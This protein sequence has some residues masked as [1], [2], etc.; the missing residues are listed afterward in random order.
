MA[1]N[2]KSGASRQKHG[3][4][5]GGAAQRRNNGSNNKSNKS[6]NAMKNRNNMW[7]NRNAPNRRNPYGGYGD[8]IDD[9]GEEEELNSS[10]QDSLY[11]N[12]KNRINNNKNN[13]KNDNSSSGSSS[14]SEETDEGVL[15]AKLNAKVKKIVTIGIIVLVLVLLLV[16][17]ILAAAIAVVGGIDDTATLESY[18]C[19]TVNIID[20]ENKGK[21]YVLKEGERLCDDVLIEKGI[22]D[23]V[24]SN[25]YVYVRTYSNVDFERYVAGVTDAEVGAICTGCHNK[26]EVLKAFAVASRSAAQGIITQDHGCYVESS[27]RFQKYVNP[28]DRSVKAAEATKGEVILKDNGEI[29]HA[30]YDAFACYDKKTDS[31]GETWYY[32]KQP[33]QTGDAIPESWLN[34]KEK[35]VFSTPWVSCEMKQAHGR[36]ASQFGAYYMA[37]V[38]NYDYKM[39]LHYYYSAYVDGTED[40]YE[41]KTKNQYEEE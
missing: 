32:I 39:L 22:K 5:K 33:I 14:S 2:V 29:L 8:D 3:T 26:E 6:P 12:I 11:N 21:D 38:H 30:T 25:Q 35:Y 13:N 17:M 7:G 23:S 31:D 41:N 1:N 15:K 36:G 27:D 20:C 4:G 9:E 40:Q 28:L 10:Q 18:N 24:T 34:E 37:D 19:E 16:L